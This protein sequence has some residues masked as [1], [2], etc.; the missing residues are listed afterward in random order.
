MIVRIRLPKQSEKVKVLEF[1]VTE[2]EYG[3]TI[4]TVEGDYNILTITHDGMLIKHDFID[5]KLGLALN[6]RG[7]IIEAPYR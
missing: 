5:D 2:S 3:V 4:K 1:Y 7:Q 6:N